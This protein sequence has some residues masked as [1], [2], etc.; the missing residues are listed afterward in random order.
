MFLDSTIIMLHLL[1][2][3]MW[4]AYAEMKV[5]SLLKK[6]QFLLSKSSWLHWSAKASESRYSYFNVKNAF[7]VALI[8]D[9]NY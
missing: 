4:S 6:K 9:I 2:M 8:S 7:S 1:Q 3:A 5:K